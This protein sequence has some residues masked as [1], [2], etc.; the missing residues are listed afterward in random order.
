M[1][2]SQ[3]PTPELTELANQIGEFIQY[4]GFKKVHGRIWTHL[5][6]SSEPLDAADLMERLKISKALVSMSLSDLTEYEVIQVAGRSER[7]TTLY[8][9]NPEVIAVILNVLRTRER[10]ILSHVAAAHKVLQES[11][12]DDRRGVP[13]DKARVRSLGEMIRSA[14]THLDGLLTLD[15]VDFSAWNQFDEK[16]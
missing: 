3:R 11:H 12:K 6:L 13:L 10:R 1:S 14:E 15:T 5:Y 7:G 8:S 16:T 9:A 2:Q 4:W